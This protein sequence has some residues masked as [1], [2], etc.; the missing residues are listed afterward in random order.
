MT[1]IISQD[2]LVITRAKQKAAEWMP[3]LQSVF[4][5]M[6]CTPNPKVPTAAVDQYG[7]MYYNPDFFGKLSVE[8]VAY[9]ILH[10][11]LHL[12]LSHHKRTRRMCPN[13]NAQKAYLANIA[14]DLCI[15]QALAEQIGSH[16]PDGIVTIGKFS[17]IP[18][19][20]A[21][22]TSEQYFEA[23]VAWQASQ[24]K[25]PPPPPQ[26]R[27]EDEDE[28]K[29]EDDW[30]DEDSG[31]PDEDSDDD[32]ESEGDDD[33]DGTTD[34]AED[35]DSESD[36]GDDYQPGEGDEDGE[37]GESG[38]ESESEEGGSESDSDGSGDGDSE[39]K[40]GSDA[41][42]EG[43]GGSGPG[44]TELDNR[45]L[46][47]LGE[48][49]N[50][51][52]AGSGSDGVEKE[53]EEEPTIAD[54]SNMEK[55]LRDAE[56]ALDELNP[57]IGS[58]AGNIRQA[59]KTRLHPQPDPFDQLAHVVSRSIASPVGQP[60]LTYRKWPRRTLPGKARLRGVQRL[61]PEATV[62]LDT[63]GSMTDN[64]VMQ[65]ALAV[66]AKGISRLQNPRIVCCDGAIQSAKRVANMSNFQ[67]DGG[68][69]TDMAAGLIHVDKTYRP[70]SIVIITDG[71]TAWPSQP[72]RAKVICAL[73]RGE[74]AN[75]IP[76]WITVVHLYRQGSQYVL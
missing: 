61:Q 62:L 26:P 17:H 57:R 72:T 18:G 19:V 31:E 11:C 23:L 51:A 71:I 14:Q 45:G 8:V 12:V 70:D 75:R 52:D 4:M 46:P 34:D 76:K 41:G 22:R 2:R 3:F 10:E 58:G 16:E 40:S 29:D 49:C 25:T 33:E 56:Q 66:V 30:E 64:S 55:R 36:S 5:P 35:G 28:D 15:Q 38:D 20:S 50:P 63:S 21:G 27:D 47:E 7:R 67:W 24:P 9:V 13:I 53:W 73:C 65:R 1:T 32:S 69:G 42:G 59:L 6:R 37:D 68:G 54:V 43:G 74:W 44:Q 48:V 39:A 60:E